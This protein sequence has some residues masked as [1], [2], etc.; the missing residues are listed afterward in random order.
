MVLLWVRS[1][2]LEKKTMG[3]THLRDKALALH[4]AEEGRP[5]RR[6]NGM[7]AEGTGF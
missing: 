6:I 3:G 7:E 1:K 2:T 5:E 4:K